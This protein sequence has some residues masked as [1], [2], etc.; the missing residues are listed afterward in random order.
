M[1]LIPSVIEVEPN[2]EMLVIDV[3]GLATGLEKLSGKKIYSSTNEEMSAEISLNNVVFTSPLTLLYT[4]QTSVEVPAI[5]VTSG[6][7]QGRGFSVNKSIEDVAQ[8]AISEVDKQ[9]KE[10]EKIIAEFRGGVEKNAKLINVT[11]QRINS[12]AAIEDVETVIN[13]FSVLTKLLNWN[14][15]IPVKKLVDAV[16]V[17]KNVADGVYQICNNEYKEELKK[18][19]EFATTTLEKLII[20]RRFGFSEEISVPIFSKK[21]D[22]YYEYVGQFDIAIMAHAIVTQK[23]AEKR[24]AAEAEAAQTAQVA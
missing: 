23:Q 17:I 11:L 18:L 16:K 7:I 19:S 3:L 8:A 14:G 13:S 21:I 2:A 10:R 15:A 20:K 24:R 5:E 9:Q 1:S 22:Q 12:A 6:A 4:Y